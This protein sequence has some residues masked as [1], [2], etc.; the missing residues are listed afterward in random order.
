VTPWRRV[1][2]RLA[3][4]ART[5]HAREAWLLCEL[6]AVRVARCKVDQRIDHVRAVIATETAR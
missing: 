5:L 2:R 4:R 6:Q 3:H 1:L